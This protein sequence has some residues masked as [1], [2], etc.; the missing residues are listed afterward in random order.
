MEN[1][2]IYECYPELIQFF[3]NKED[4]Y[5]YTIRSDK[6]CL[7]KCPECGHEHYMI[8]HNLTRRHYSCPIC[9]SG[10]SFPERLMLSIFDML[11]IEYIYQLSNKNFDW[12]KKYRYD[13]FLK[14]ENTIIET[15]GSQHYFSQFKFKNAKTI[16]EQKKIDDIKK[17]IA[18][19]NGISNYIYI[20]FSN[21]DFK[22]IKQNICESLKNFVNLDKIDWEKCVKNASKSKIIEACNLWEE[23]KNKLTTTEMANILRISRDTLVRYLNKGNA[24]GFCSYDG[25]LERKKAAIKGG[26]VIRKKR[27]K[28][29]EVY[30]LN[31]NF[32]MEFNSAKEL[33][34]NSKKIFGVQFRYESIICTCTGGQ[35]T[36]R[37]Y[38]IKYKKND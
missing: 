36:H 23:Q 1:N 22:K 17:E 7:M 3:K 28:K 8:I 20:D 27:S 14:K 26:D 10:K 9:N 2:K 4:A 33:E 5:R 21:R 30:D 32:I 37:G 38:K 6:K 11:N 29:I 15:N 13:F 31:D 34:K 35:K 24:F 25:K 16:E 18:I 19:K 12:C